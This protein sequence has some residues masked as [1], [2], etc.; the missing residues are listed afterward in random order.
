LG[1]VVSFVGPVD[2]V[3]KNDKAFRPTSSSCPPSLPP[4]PLPSISAS[5]RKDN[6]APYQL[7]FIYREMNLLSGKKM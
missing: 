7:Y 2:M 5:L 6:A 4:S 3:R 1:E